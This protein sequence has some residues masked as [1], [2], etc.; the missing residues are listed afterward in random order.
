MSADH[1]GH[2]SSLLAAAP[3]L[4][5]RMRSLASLVAQQAAPALMRAYAGAAGAVVPASSPFLRFSN[6]YPTP[7]DHTPL[8][9]TIPDTKVRGCLSG[10]YA[11]GGCTVR[12]GSF[13]LEEREHWTHSD[14]KSSRGCS[15]PWLCAAWW[16]SSIRSEPSYTCSDCHGRPREGR[17]ACGGTGSACIS[18]A[19]RGA[20]H[21]PAGASR[22][23]VACAALLRC[24][25]HRGRQ[26]GP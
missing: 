22:C 4:A 11:G 6:P 8:L 12:R 7:V 9:S 14:L 3:P 16:R 26:T 1:S 21:T 19:A 10:C 25:G 15:V 2:F 23:C 17:E 5:A 24:D 13:V 18:R 20:A